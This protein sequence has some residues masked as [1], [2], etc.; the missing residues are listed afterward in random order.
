MEKKESL[1]LKRLRKQTGKRN[2]VHTCDNCKC[3]RYSPCTCQ[4]KLKKEK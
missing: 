4:R 3:T 1:G 2:L